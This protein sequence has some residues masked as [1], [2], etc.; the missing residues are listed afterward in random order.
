MEC[1]AFYCPTENLPRSFKRVDEK[2]HW[3]EQN[4]NVKTTH[5]DLSEENMN[6]TVMD[7]T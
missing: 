2:W 6:Y 4:I 7:M 1:K 3:S 5:V